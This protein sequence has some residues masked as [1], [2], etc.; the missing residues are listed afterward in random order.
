MVKRWCL[1]C[2]LLVPGTAAADV[3]LFFGGGLSLLTLEE[4]GFEDVSPTNVFLRLG[5]AL[6]RY[7]E[8]GVE[9]NFTIV[10]D[11]IDV[12]GQQFEA[13]LD[14]TTLYV[15]GNVPVSDAAALFV[16]I[17]SATSE[18]T[19]ERGSLSGSEDDDDTALGVGLEI[20]SQGDASFIVDY[21]QYFDDGIASIEGVNLGF[22]KR[23]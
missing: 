8:L 17:G 23:F 20:H 1:L 4:A 7:V 2:V 15:Q 14:V 13:E 5:L 19:L 21:V 11:E 18:L 6:N 22:R 9:G 10:E 12:L 3:R 16:L